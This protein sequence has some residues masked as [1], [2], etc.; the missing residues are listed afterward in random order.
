MGRANSW[1][2][3]ALLAKVYLTLNRKADALVLLNDVINNSGYSL[4]PN[5]AGVFSTLN[6][7]NAE[8]L[9]SVRYKSGKVG[10]GSPFANLFAP[11]NSG[12][13]VVNGDGQGYNYP[14]VELAGMYNNL[15]AGWDFQTTTNGGTAVAV[16][17]NCP[18]AFTANF[19]SGNLYLDGTNGSSNWVTSATGNELAGLGGSSTNTTGTNFS[20]VTSSPAALAFKGGI[21][22]V[23]NGKY[24][25]FKFSMTGCQN[26]SVSYVTRST[27]SGFTSQLWEYSTNGT[28]WFPAETITNIDTNS[29]KLKTLAIITT[30][31][32]AP[33]AYL[34]FSGSGATSAT[35]LNRIDNLQFNA[36][37]SRGSFNIGQ[38]FGNLYVNKYISNLIYENDGENDWPVIRFADVILMWAEA[39]GNSPQSLDYINQVR[40]RSGASALS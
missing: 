34:R 19:G 21:S 29:Y 26:L 40:T 1:A 37:N 14:T 28:T 20:T 5:Y 32:N 12:L 38:Y 7:M 39:T 22:G 18:S 24:A 30:L 11:N 13:A 27:S 2:A 31:N 36:T 25:V 10:L 33:T 35:G 8:I 3:R 16:S 4:L 23:A 15:I 6:E 9:F 17:P